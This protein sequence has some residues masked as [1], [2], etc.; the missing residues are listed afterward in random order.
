MRR[1]LPFRLPPLPGDPDSTAPRNGT[2]FETTHVVP[3]SGEQL[4]ILGVV[5]SLMASLGLLAYKRWFFHSSWRKI[6]LWTTW[7]VTAFSALQILLI[8]RCAVAW[9]CFVCFACSVVATVNV[10]VYVYV[11]APHL[12][13]IYVRLFDILYL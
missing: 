1:L 3:P 9:V 13:Q 2:Y 10:N 8:L 11:C 6:Y 5:G 4:G 7:I 12:G